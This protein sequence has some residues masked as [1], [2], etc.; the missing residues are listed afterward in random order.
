MNTVITNVQIFDG[1]SSSLYPGEVELQGNRILHVAPGREQ[2]SVE[3]KRTL[4]GAGATLMPG[5]VNTHAHL[6][7]PAVVTLAEVG[8]MPV[9]E[10]M[11]EASYNARTALDFGFT[12]VVSGAAAKPRLDIV[13][14][15]EINAGRTPGP[16]MLAASPEMTVSGGLADGSVWEREIPANGLVADT[17][18]EF[19]R[20]VRLMVREGVD[21]IK[22]NNSGDSFCY[23]RVG[24]IINPMT[25]EEV[26][27]ICETT[28]NLGRRLAAHAHADSSVTQC[29]QYGVEFIYHATFVTDPTIEALE[30]VK[31]KHWVT[32]AFGLRYNMH[33][34][35]AEWGITPE[36]SEKIGNKREFDATIENMNKMREAGIKVLPFGDY[37][38][39]MI[40]LGTDSRDLQHFVNYFG[41]EPWEALRAATAYGGEA[42]AAE[43]VGQIK[44]GFLADLLLID[45]DPLQD[46]S[47]LLER[48]R[49]LMI[50]KD[51]QYYK[52]PSSLKQPG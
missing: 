44:P 25:E 40:P 3:G 16:R 19:R 18:A 39:K 28:T 42:F 45:G 33:F 30:K 6:T 24:S 52:A 49:F 51:G 48:D 17:P 26:R 32:P 7:Y 47:L 13:L 29:I 9:E 4:D 22:F 5:L 27:V 2:L 23:P 21:L 35:S 15:N 12:A 11:M 38:F 41:Y 46:L 34:E 36:I 10:N 1:T 50:M 43:P 14:R 8:Q 31:D 20:I 37:G